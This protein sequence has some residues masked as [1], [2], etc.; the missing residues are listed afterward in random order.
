MITALDVSCGEMI[1]LFVCLF[2]GGG[3][4]FADYE[5]S[6]TRELLYHLLAQP[7]MV[8][9]DNTEVC[10]IRPLVQEVRLIQLF[11]C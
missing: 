2:E 4:K 8:S 9:P 5:F 3:W 7:W 1:L 11:W 6:T 10:L